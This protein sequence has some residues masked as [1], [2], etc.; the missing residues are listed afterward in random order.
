[1]QIRKEELKLSLFTNMLL[2]IEDP[3]D[4]TKKTNKQI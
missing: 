4:S 2:Y 1:M 3:K